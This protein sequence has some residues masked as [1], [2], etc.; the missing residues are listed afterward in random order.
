MKYPLLFI[1]ALSINFS[2]NLFN[3]Q[4]VLNAEQPLYT[5]GQINFVV[6]GSES[7]QPHF[8]K[9][10]LLLH[11]FEYEDARE[12]FIKSQK[13]D[14]EF[15]MA[16][17]GEAMTF[18]HSLWQR[19]DKEKGIEALNKL[20][21]NPEERLTFAKTDI[22]KDFLNSIEILY[23]SGTKYER[24]LSYS[25]YF[26]DLKAKYPNNHEVAAFYAISLLGSSRNGRDEKLYNQSA[27]IVKGIINENPGHPGALHY[28]IH[29]YDDPEHAHLA[30]TAADS[31][32]EIA[33]DA[34]HALHM[35][36]HI[37]VALGSWNE[38]VQSNIASWNA[39]IKRM[40]RK[41][42]DD[43]R[44]YHA[45]SW[46]QYGLLQ[47]GEVNLATELLERMVEYASDKPSKPYRSYLLAMKGAHMVETNIWD[48]TLSDIE[49][50]TDDLNIADQAGYSFLKGMK[51]FHL[52]DNIGLSAIIGDMQKARIIAEGMVGENGFAM[53]SGG[54]FANSPPNQ[55]D[56]DMAHIMEMQLKVRR[57]ILSGNSIGAKD[58]FE[59]AT[60]IEDL[61][62]YSFGPPVVLKPIHE[63]YAEWLLGSNEPASALEFFEKSL[64]R[65]PRR[66]L[67]LEGKKKAA[68]LIDDNR[69]ITELSREIETSRSPK[70]RAQIL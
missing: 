45:Y 48:G 15:S 23:G 41:E 58:W 53:C 40:A 64:Q 69:A 21:P 18:N 59:K 13:K 52:N 27:R 29:S 5:L 16:Y 57:E 37:Y 67:S 26:G 33:P 25:A 14:P 56:I 43:A 51:S 60:A 30:K 12:E 49:L 42:L 38:V 6:G 61:L 68:E 54:G 31:Y 66:L 24:D 46:L 55:M 62:S 22:E 9:G 35:P 20:A 17:W 50:N 32:S 11:S 2:C 44:N 39:S 70:E 1:A 10:L 7:A 19:Q 65:H 4:S 47:R 8:K 3:R 36:S 63:D 34:A 28:L